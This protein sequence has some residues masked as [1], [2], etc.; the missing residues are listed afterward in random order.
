[1]LT[2]VAFENLTELTHLDGVWRYPGE[3]AVLDAAL[4]ERY[5][6]RGLAL[7]LAVPVGHGAADPADP[8]DAPLP[9]P[10]RR[11]GHIVAAYALEGDDEYLA[12]SVESI[13]Q[14]ADRILLAAPGNEAPHGLPD[15][16]GKIEVLRGTGHD[17]AD[18]RRACAQRLRPGDWLLP[19]SAD[20]VCTAAGLHRLAQLMQDYEVIVAAT[21]MFW[22][23]FRTLGTGRWDEAREVKALR[24]R[25]GY[26]YRHHACPADA[27][28]RL[29]T[30]NG[31]LALR[32]AERFSCRY[33][34]VRPRAALPLQVERWRRR[35]G[36][37]R[38]RYL[39]QVFLRWRR[40][41]Q[42][43]E[44]RYGTHPRGAGGTR[45]FA[46][47]HPEPIARRLASGELGGEA[48]Q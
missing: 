40:E 1:V 26:H 7:P 24:W 15:P 43:V 28:G 29:V 17:L 12:A 18:Q 13:Y 27:A 42:L 47:A 45:Q 37:L 32:T 10:P 11:T 34:W 3:W 48:Y 19:L 22:N 25:A 14:F 8:C 23:N 36:D 41:P 38:P 21:W 33:A 2:R 9:A 31:T 16:V 30:A 20:E 6:A 46:G 44:R 4:A 5:I 35:H 39:E